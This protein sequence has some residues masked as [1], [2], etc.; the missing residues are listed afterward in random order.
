MLCL[1]PGDLR[2]DAALPKQ[3]AVL[4]VVVAAV[5]GHPVRPPPRPTDHAAYARHCID[6]RDQLGDVVAIAARERVGERDPGCVDEKV[7]LGAASASVHRAPAR[8]GAPF[9]ACT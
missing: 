2:F 4:V 5:G 1:A 7:V 9:F 3:T 8:F 6:E